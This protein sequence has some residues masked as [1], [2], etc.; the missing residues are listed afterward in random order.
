MNLPRR[1]I[2]ITSC[3]VLITSMS[4]ARFVTGGS[5]MSRPVVVEPDPCS[6]LTPAEASVAIEQTSVA[7]KQLPDV[8]KSCFWSH[9]PTGADSSRRVVLVVV[10]AS[11][12]QTARRGMY[13]KIEPAAGVGDEA[14]Y[15]TYPNNP[16]PLIWVKKGETNFTIRMITVLK[17]KPPFTLEEAQAK[18]LVLAKAAVGKA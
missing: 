6:L 1:I 14:F 17:P 12:F 4:A 18:L 5:R 13:N 2:S 10:T 11:Q 9:S 16:L 3:G 7:G 15:Q 8:P